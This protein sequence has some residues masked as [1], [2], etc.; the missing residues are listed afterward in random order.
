[1]KKSGMIL[2]ALIDLAAAPQASKPAARPLETK[3]SVKK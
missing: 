1:M 3:P 2:T